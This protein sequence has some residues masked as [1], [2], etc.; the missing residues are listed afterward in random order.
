M[1]Q[2]QPDFKE[3]T[4]LQKFRSRIQ[5]IQQHLQIID[6]SLT[7]TGK[8]LGRY[9]PTT[10]SINLAMG[11][12]GTT[13][14]KLNHPTNT[15]GR[16]ISYSRAKNAEYS[17]IELYSCF[18]EYMKNILGEMY[19]KEPIKIV[20]KIAD[21][22]KDNKLTFAEIVQLGDY[23]KISELMVTKVFRKLENERSTTLLLEKVLNHTKIKL[24]DN[25]K[26]QSLMYLQ[27]RHLFIHNKGVADKL[28]VDEF[29]DL[30]SVKVGNKLPANFATINNA[31]TIVLTLCDSI[32]K[33]LI[34]ENLVIKRE[35]VKK[36]SS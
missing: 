3:T 31:M 34:K 29:G 9:K 17:I 35:L 5:Y 8:F 2:K 33:E 14:D 13:H 18:T 30:H 32:D 27:M 1:A 20:Q 19:K 24:D 7:K 22:N 26:R 36:S 12:D 11:E 28:F 4:A 16:I 10:T 21:E 6:A 15:N 23:S 25:T